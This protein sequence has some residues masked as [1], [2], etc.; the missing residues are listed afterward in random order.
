MNIAVMLIYKSETSESPRM[1]GLATM[2]RE[3]IK[4]VVL[5]FVAVWLHRYMRE[6]NDLMKNVDNLLGQTSSCN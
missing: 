3:K 4:C 2:Y 1:F 6:Y 5:V